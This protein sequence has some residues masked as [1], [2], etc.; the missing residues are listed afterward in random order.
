MKKVIGIS[1]LVV[2]VIVGI[3]GF[4]QQSEDNKIVEIGDVEV[5]QDFTENI[6]I[7]MI[8]GTIVAVGGVV[9]LAVGKGS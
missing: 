9:V 7:M 6:N 2:G 3:L 5:K 8:A 1:L 4:V